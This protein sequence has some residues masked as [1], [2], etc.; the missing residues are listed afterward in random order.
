MN[1]LV[2]RNVEEKSQRIQSTKIPGEIKAGKKTP[3]EKI[4]GILT[5][6]FNRSSVEE[7]D[8][9]NRGELMAKQIN[10]A[11]YIAGKYISGWPGSVE[12]TNR[13]LKRWELQ[14]KDLK[15]KTLKK[16]PS[17]CFSRKIG[18]GALEVAVIL[19]EKINYRVVDREILEH[20]ASTANLSDQTAA[21][22]DERYPGKIS[23]MLSFLFGEK[24]FVK[25]DYSRHLFATILSFAGLEPTI[26]VGRGAH[27]IL[28]RDEVLAV[29]LISCRENRQKRLEKI[30]GISSSEA[31]K[32]LKRMDKEQ[33]DFFVKT[34]GKKDASPYEFDLVINR[35][36]I[37]GASEAAQIVE[38]AFREKFK[39]P[40][41]T[42]PK[43]S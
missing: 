17:I 12:G 28:P 24:A 15:E 9:K 31:E 19:G 1:R 7:F 27:L 34:Y 37:Q 2:A 35:D 26:F 5:I 29:R 22:F 40:V 43:N 18:V 13:F 36:F 41:T 16:A 39:I 8:K 14:K 10:I 6:I 11:R 23:E 20:I 25:S 42:I 4:G 21:Y 33:R 30:M 32:E 3:E 38:T